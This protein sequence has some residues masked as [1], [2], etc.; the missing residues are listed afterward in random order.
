ME[1][2]NNQ[3]TNFFPISLDDLDTNL[4]RIITVHIQLRLIYQDC[5]LITKILFCQLTIALLV[6]SISS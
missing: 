1:S 2:I 4:P 5:N 6:H 3:D